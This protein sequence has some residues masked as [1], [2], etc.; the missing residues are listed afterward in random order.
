M[1]AVFDL[2]ADIGIEFRGILAECAAMQR[3][4]TVRD[5]ADYIY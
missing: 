2:A 5:M 3:G 4:Q 1:A